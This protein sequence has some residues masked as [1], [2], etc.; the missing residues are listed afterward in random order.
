MAAVIT[1][2]RN[3][4]GL[5]GELAVRTVPAKEKPAYR[6]IDP[7]VEFAGAVIDDDDVAPAVSVDA[8]HGPAGVRV[9]PSTPPA[10][11]AAEPL[12][13]G[14]LEQAACIVSLFAEQRGLAH[15]VTD[16]QRV[17]FRALAERLADFAEANPTSS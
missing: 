8:E 12:T 14:D 17:E 9:S 10:G 16:R 2:L 13:V 6:L 1:V 7:L 3:A 11:R 15:P 4:M 5:L